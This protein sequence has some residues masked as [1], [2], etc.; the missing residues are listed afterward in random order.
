MEIM[1]S[2]TKENYFVR[3][4][5]RFK[6]L[7]EKET[8]RLLDT[9]IGGDVIIRGVKLRHDYESEG[10]YGS[11]SRYFSDG[12]TLVRVSNHWSDGVHSSGCCGWIR[13]CWWVL[14]GP[15][16]KGEC[17]GYWSGITRISDMKSW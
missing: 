8:E 11:H 5:G 3:S 6:R 4:V 9:P 14:S 10:S 17:C 15:W 16:H 12:E 7:T 13:S 1:V 2:C